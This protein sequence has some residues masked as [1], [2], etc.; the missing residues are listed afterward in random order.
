MTIPTN[1]IGVACC[2]DCG[3]E[4]EVA[5]PKRCKNAGVAIA[6]AAPAPTRKVKKV[7]ETRPGQVC[8]ACRK[9]RVSWIGVGRQ[10]ERCDECKA[11]GRQVLP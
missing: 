6:A 3:E 2:D 1:E 10:P 9:N 5:C 8:R 7:R 11:A 4:L